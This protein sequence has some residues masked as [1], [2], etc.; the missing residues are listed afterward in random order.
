MIK[1]VKITFGD[2]KIKLGISRADI[3]DFVLKQTMDNQYIRLMHTGCV[4]T[5]KSMRTIWR[6]MIPILLYR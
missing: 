4:K 5:Q 6:Q 2:K 3:A 1:D